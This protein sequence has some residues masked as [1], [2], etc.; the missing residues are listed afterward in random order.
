M[1]VLKSFAV[2]IMRLASWVYPYSLSVKI[3]GYRNYLYFLWIRN[4]IG[5]VGDKVSIHYPCL[6]QGGGEKNISIGDS[7]CL[8]GHNVLGCWSKYKDQT[9]N[10]SI[11]IGNGCNIGEYTH[12]TAI[13]SITIGDGVLTGRFVYIGDNAHGGLSY[14]E[15][16]IP[17]EQR[18]LVS[19]GKI[20]I[21]KNVWIGDKVTILGGVTIGDNV[22]IAAN[23]VVVNDIPSNCVAAG[24]PAKVVKRLS[25]E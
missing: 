20:L 3:K 10:P 11:T 7:T 5:K 4:F 14:D 18:N 8:Q 12:I 15:A 25:S 22:I 19:K 23:A 21:G 1:I 2:L 6:V 9:Y 16:E 17:P 13:N 24:V